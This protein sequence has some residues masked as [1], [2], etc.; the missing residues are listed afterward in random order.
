MSQQVVTKNPTSTA[1]IV[2]GWT[3]PQNAYASDNARASA[4]I[5]NA[6][7]E[8]GGYGFAVPENATIN[9][10]EVGLEGY[11]SAGEQL[12]VKIY[13]GSSWYAKTALIRSGEQLEWLDF[14]AYT[15]WIPEK[16]NAVK[17][18]IVFR[19]T[20]GGGDTCYPKETFLLCVDVDR[21]YLLKQCNEIRPGDMVLGYRKDQG[22]HCCRVVNAEKHEGEFELLKITVDK[23][24]IVKGADVSKLKDFKP[25]KE[26]IYVTPNHEVCSPTHYGR[27][28]CGE[29]REGDLLVDL[30]LGRMINVPIIKIEKS[31]YK[32]TVYNV[33]L[34]P[35]YEDFFYFIISLENEHIK[36]LEKLLGKKWNFFKNVEFA[37]LGL[38]IK[39]W[40]VD[41]LPVRVTYTEAISM[42]GYSTKMSLTK[43]G[44]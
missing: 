29:L 15:Q 38:A 24:P 22:Y 9:K 4:N 33:K 18:R 26:Y 40:Y 30:H 42:A 3:N 21:N 13:D 11:T 37:L 6:E 7:Q 16:V 17:T 25:W 20:S 43:T 31:K 14:T 2:A 39:T 44:N 27:T 23:S 41:W 10:V 28:K 1:T 8:Y 35:H 19:G 36:V 12:D 32:G 34:E 5:E